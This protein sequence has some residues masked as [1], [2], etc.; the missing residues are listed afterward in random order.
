[1]GR[2][3][4]NSVFRAITILE[5]FAFGKPE[6]NLVE[7]AEKLSL[8]VSTLHRQ[9]KTLVEYGVL[10]QNADGKRYQTG[11]DLIA[12]AYAIVNQYALRDLARPAL[13]RLSEA[14][15]ETIHLT[16]LNGF[17]VLYVDRVECLH[18]VRTVGNIGARIPAHATGSGKALMS[19]FSD[20]M[21]EKYC[22]L[23]PTV[24][25]YTANTILDADRLASALRSVRELGYAV[26]D[27]ECEEGLFCI[28]APIRDTKGSIVAS[29]SIAGPTFRVKQ[30]LE[31]YIPE[32][33]Q[34][35]RE[36]S[37]AMGVR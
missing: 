4:V 32:V 27:E 6:W 35:A 24:P 36:I 26:D 11:P 8:P 15:G 25:Q 16:Q 37:R 34:A 23:L 31:R 2:N 10:Q 33:K 1:M 7:L 20:E 28:A 9:L 12:F 18:S 17:D 19:E 14:V 30:N 5:C 21:F 3:T 29:V 22:E 13:K